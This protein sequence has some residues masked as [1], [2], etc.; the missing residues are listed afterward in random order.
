MM[1]KFAPEHLAGLLAEHPVTVTGAS[2]AFYQMMLSAQ[3]GS[4]RSEP[5]V[6]SLR[7]LI[8]GGAR[9]PAELPQAGSANISAFRSCTH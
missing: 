1:P 9:L 2:T 7:M 8:G 4:G 5:V 3:L 6:P